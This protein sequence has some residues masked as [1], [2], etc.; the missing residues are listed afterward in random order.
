MV[1]EEYSCLILSANS[2]RYS[3]ET[4]GLPEHGKMN[5]R[6][7]VGFGACCDLLLLLVL[8]TRFAITGD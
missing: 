5:W 1:L 4:E 6:E 2:S 3:G 8:G 7:C